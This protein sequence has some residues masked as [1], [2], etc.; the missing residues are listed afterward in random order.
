MNDLFSS[1]YE[2]FY[3]NES[4]SQNLYDEKFYAQIGLTTCLSSLFIAVLF[5]Y[6]INRPSFSR[7]YHWLILGLINCAINFF[8]AYQFPKI[9]FE[10]LELEF[11]TEYFTFAFWN[12]LIS[13]ICYLIFSF[14]IRWWST[15]CK[16]TPIPR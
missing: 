13:F 11:T 9:K 7:W 16:N 1:I 12:V 5:Y 10:S 6:I 14:S 4:F 3:Y 8:H 2:L 15:N